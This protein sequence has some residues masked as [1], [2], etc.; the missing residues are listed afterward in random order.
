MN[1]LPLLASNKLW[2]HCI[3]GVHKWP[4]KTSVRCLLSPSY[5]CEQEWQSRLDNALLSKISPGNQ[6]DSRPEP[7]VG[8]F[9]IANRNLFF[10]LILQW[11][12]PEIPK[13]TH[14]E[15][16]RCGHLCQSRD[17]I[18]TV[19]RVA[20]FGLSL[21]PNQR[22]GKHTGINSSLILSGFHQ[23][24]RNRSIASHFVRPNWF[25]CLSRLLL[26]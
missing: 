1:C 24:R 25:R 26:L 16:S 19:G 18:R 5:S 22:D 20:A 15:C 4:N 14:S 7:L 13:E 23:I 9:L 6:L 8:L 21:T 2:L 17:P 10:R 3:K 11:T 12:Q